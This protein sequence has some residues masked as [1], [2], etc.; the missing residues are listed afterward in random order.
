MIATE[1]LPILGICGF[2]GSGKTTLIVGLLNH[3]EQRGL[4]IAVVKHSS[5]SLQLDKAGKDSDRF[6]QAGAHVYLSNDRQSFVRYRSD[7]SLSFTYQLLELARLY[8]LVLVEGYKKTPIFKVWLLGEGEEQQPA[9]CTQVVSVL[10]RD[11]HRVAS[12]LSLLDDWLPKV[13]RS[14]LV[15]G[16]LLIG[17]QSSRMGRPKHLISH[18]GKRWMDVALEKLDV[19]CD[20][21]VVAGRGELPQH[22]DLERLP[23]PPGIKGPMAGIIAALRWNP[24]AVWL[25][26]ACDLPE[27]DVRALQWLLEMRQPG[28]WAVLP[29]I[30]GQRPEPLLA[31]YDFRIQRALEEMVAVGNDRPSSL[32]EHSKVA[33]L[34]PPADL[35]GSWRNVNYPE[36]V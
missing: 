33:L 31:C 34:P 29:T 36:E 21:I 30:D 2:S 28:K 10:R 32:A 20:R 23:D 25:V 9:G 11:N 8:D 27:V 15:Y 19:V 14:P 1:M 7:N 6:Y 35:L 24:W 18:N 17:G 22:R 26:M 4:K 12:L 13:W 3:L 16:A 5:S